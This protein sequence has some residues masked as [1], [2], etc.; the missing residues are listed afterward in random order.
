[1]IDMPY[2]IWSEIIQQNCCLGIYGNKERLVL[3]VASGDRGNNYEWAN[4]N[5][6][7]TPIAKSW[8]VESETQV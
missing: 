7:R 4:S 6:V 5:N 1:M 8:I 3:I 2:S